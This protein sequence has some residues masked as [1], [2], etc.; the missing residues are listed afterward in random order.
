MEILV[1]RGLS[2][3]HFVAG[4]ACFLLLF[5][6]QSWVNNGGIMYTWATA[7]SFSL[8]VPIRKKSFKS[9]LECPNNVVKE[10]NNNQWANTFY[11]R[12]LTVLI[13]EVHSSIHYGLSDL[14]YYFHCYC[15][16]WTL[17][18][19]KIMNEKLVTAIIFNCIIKYLLLYFQTKSVVDDVA[20]FHIFL[21]TWMGTM[22]FLFH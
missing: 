8:K 3:S 20:S 19:I 13:L 22:L 14:A 1:G 21:W 2:T 10:Y 17:E 16:L 9:E 4:S 5:W 6:L 18:W 11:V 7:S 15:L 12:K